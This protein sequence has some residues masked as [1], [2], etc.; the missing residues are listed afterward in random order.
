MLYSR[1]DGYRQINK[2]YDCEELQDGTMGVRDLASALLAVGEL[3][4][5]VNR[6]LSGDK[7]EVTVHHMSNPTRET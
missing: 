2:T 1:R 7:S 5:Q 4:T 3:F 6:V